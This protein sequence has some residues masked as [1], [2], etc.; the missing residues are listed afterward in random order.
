MRKMLHL[1]EATIVIHNLLIDLGEDEHEEWIDHEDFSDMD[2]AERA[3]FEEGDPLNTAIPDRAP[4]DARRTRLMHYFE[5]N[6]Y[7]VGR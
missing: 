2:D 1:L 4:K 5:E 3:P 6:H 7:F